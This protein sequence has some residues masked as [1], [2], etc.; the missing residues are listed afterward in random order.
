MIYTITVLN[1]IHIIIFLFSFSTRLVSILLNKK[2]SNFQ[3]KDI[4]FCS[5][6]EGLV[7]WG[8]DLVNLLNIV[9]TKLIGQHFVLRCAH[10]PGITLLFAGCFRLHRNWWWECS[11]SWILANLL[12]D[13]NPCQN[14]TQQPTSRVNT[15]M[16]ISSYQRCLFTCSLKL[17]WH[18]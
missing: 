7:F 14:A 8:I 17:K 16:S 15:F 1:L 4:L 12:S 11:C 9:E 18:Y 10:I 2:S 5:G 13:I 6:R 3:G